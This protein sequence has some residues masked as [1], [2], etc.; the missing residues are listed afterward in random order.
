MFCFSDIESG[1]LLMPVYDVAMLKAMLYNAMKK[2]SGK[3][4]STLNSVH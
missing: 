2:L 4:Y 3:V 1:F